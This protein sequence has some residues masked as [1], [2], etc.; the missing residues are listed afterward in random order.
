MKILDNAVITKCGECGE[1]YRENSMFYCAH[2]NHAIE[3]AY[4]IDKDC[5]LQECEVIPAKDL[6]CNYDFGGDKRTFMEVGF[7]IRNCNESDID[8]IIIVKKG[9][10]NDLI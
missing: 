10:K 1:K 5:P 4:I 2:D 6:R 3:N 9:I 8:H 7:D